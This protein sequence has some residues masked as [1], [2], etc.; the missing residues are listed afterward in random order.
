M[1]DEGVSA[2][3]IQIDLGDL[4]LLLGLD[5]SRVRL[6]SVGTDPI[7]NA[8]FLYT[9]SIED[10]DEYISEWMG[11]VTIKLNEERELE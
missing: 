8:A 4:A 9:A 1:N 5:S 6:I 7:L 2:Q 10:G 3:K 11:N